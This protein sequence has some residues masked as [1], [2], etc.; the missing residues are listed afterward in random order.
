VIFRLRGVPADAILVQECDRDYCGA[1]TVHGPIGRLKWRW[2]DEAKRTVRPEVGCR[3][4]GTPCGESFELEPVN[5][6]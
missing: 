1:S 6:S 2:A 5:I 3:G 4:C